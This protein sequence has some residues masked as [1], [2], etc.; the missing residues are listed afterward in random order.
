MD[1]NAQCSG[2]E[3]PEC[4]VDHAEQPYRELLCA[5]ELPE[6]M[7]EPLASIGRLA[8]ELRPQDAVGDVGEHRATPLVVGAADG[9]V[10]G[11]DPEYAGGARAVRAE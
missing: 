6:P 10:I 8:H 2:L 7:P 9:A 5:V 3:V 1:G 4:D 11:G